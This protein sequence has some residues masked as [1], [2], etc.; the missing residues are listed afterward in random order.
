MPRTRGLSH[1][2]LHVSNLELSVSFYMGVFGL[3]LLSQGI[4][5][6]ERDRQPLELRQAWLST[7]G[8]EDLLALTCAS[9]LPMGSAGLNHI[10]FN[11]YSDE[12]VLEALAVVPMHGGKVVRTGEREEIGIR[13]FFA[14]VRDPDGYT[15][16]LSTQVLVSS[17]RTRRATD[18]SKLFRAE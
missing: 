9:S 13:E 10:G 5:T 18:H 11:F 8:Q 1:V 7:P 14:Y 12:D 15:I 4:E 6:V 16:E 17:Q 2:N 3:E